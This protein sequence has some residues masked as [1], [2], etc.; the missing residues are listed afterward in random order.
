[1]NS[2]RIK[3]RIRKSNITIHVYTK[4]SS[5]DED[6][7]KN[8]LKPR[9]VVITTNLGARGSDFA[10]DDT[11]EQEWRTACVGYFHADE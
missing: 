10:T 11:V 6:H 5:D 3:K 8:I 2:L 1:M 9:D 4:N 7:V